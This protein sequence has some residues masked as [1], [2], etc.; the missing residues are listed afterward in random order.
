MSSQFDKHTY[1]RIPLCSELFIWKILCAIW[2]STAPFSIYFDIVYRIWHSIRHERYLPKSLVQSLFIG[3][4]I[5]WKNG[6]YSTLLFVADKNFSWKN[7]K[8]IDRFQDYDN[9]SWVYHWE[10]SSEKSEV[11]EDNFE[12]SAGKISGLSNC[13]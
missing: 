2:S 1:S 11:S 6:R 13:F 5:R 7:I 3:H 10:Q 8:L 9:K 4:P 12:T